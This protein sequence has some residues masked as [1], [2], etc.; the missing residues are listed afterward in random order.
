MVAEMLQKSEFLLYVL[1]SYYMKFY[2]RYLFYN[3]VTSFII[4]LLNINYIFICIL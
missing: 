1:Y 2:F 4:Y 3:Y